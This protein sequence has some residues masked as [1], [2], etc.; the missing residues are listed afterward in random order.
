M[1]GAVRDAAAVTQA[2]TFVA[3]IVAVVPQDRVEDTAPALE[4]M[5]ARAAVR[6]VLIS[7]GDTPQPEVS[8]TERATTIHGLVPRYLNNAVAALRLSSLPTLAWWRGGDRA[9]LEQLA[10]LVDRVLL[11]TPDPAQDWPLVARISERAAISDVRWT[12][13]TR[14][15]SLMARFFDLPEI[16]AQAGAITSLEIAAS[17]PDAARLYAGWI[18]SSLPQGRQVAVTVGEPQDAAP[19]ESILLRGGGIEL[20]LAL[21]STRTCIE[22]SVTSGGAGAMSRVVPLGDQDIVALV[23][24]ELRLRSRDEAFERAVREIVER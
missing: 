1:A 23:A 18:A 5:R 8:R 24:E 4:R 12:K 10:V 22:S 14:W 19:I 3:T 11:D 2:Q 16:R 17:D 15:R 20:R 9:A 13:L 21:S 6:T 7:L